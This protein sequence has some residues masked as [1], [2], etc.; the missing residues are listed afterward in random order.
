MAVTALGSFIKLGVNADL[1]YYT[2]SE[3]SNK[4]ERN[5][6]QMQYRTNKRTGDKISEIGLGSAY[7]FS[8]G[9]ENAVKALRRAY[10]LG[11]NFY[12]LAAGDGASFPIYGEAFKDIR[13]NIFFQIHF[14]ADYT[15]GTY[16]WSL[17]LDR[18]KSSIDWQ[19]KNLKTD[20]IDYGFIHCQDEVSDWETFLKNGI[21]DYILKNFKNGEPIFLY[22]IPGSS[23]EVIRQETGAIN[24]ETE[25]LY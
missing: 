6:P 22:E 11:I 24:E 1:L 3:N 2:N 5:I 13:K 16:G 18:V 20:Y 10:E 14:G 9:M 25:T 8:A 19:L 7:M 17:N 15:N 23:K 4:S 21:Y 12:D